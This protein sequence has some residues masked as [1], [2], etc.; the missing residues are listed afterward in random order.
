MKWQAIRKEV[1]DSAA[2]AVGGRENLALKINRSKRQLAEYR[3]KESAPAD[4]AWQ[5]GRIA[6]VTLDILL[7]NG[8]H[9]EQP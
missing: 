6:K 9:K 7:E 5:I 1:I 8:E 3:S 2:G 4:V